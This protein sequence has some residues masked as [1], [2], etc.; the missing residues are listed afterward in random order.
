MPQQ[1]HRVEFLLRR[2]ELQSLGEEVPREWPWVC[3]RLA[4]DPVPR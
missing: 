2:P 1:A 4:E 3:L